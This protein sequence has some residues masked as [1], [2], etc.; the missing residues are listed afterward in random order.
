MLVD[1]SIRLTDLAPAWGLVQMV[2]EDGTIEREY[3]VSG[4]AVE[5][6]NSGKR[7]CPPGC[8]LE[9]WRTGRV[10]LAGRPLE[11]G[12]ALMNKTDGS[13][14]VNFGVQ[15]V[16]D[17]I[18][19]NVMVVPKHQWERVGHDGVRMD[20]RLAKLLDVGYRPVQAEEV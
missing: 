6:V 12:L 1:T 16:G 9:Q 5:A 3:I 14:A 11:P 2:N 8:T 15:R 18:K 4:E 10:A 13:L 7:E 19:T 20:A 17:R